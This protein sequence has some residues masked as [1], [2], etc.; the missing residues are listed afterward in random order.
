[1]PSSSRMRALSSCC[2]LVVL[3]ILLLV[4]HAPLFLNDGVVMDDWLVLKLRPDYPIDL[5]FLVHGAGHPIFFGYYRLI[6]Q[7]RRQNNHE[8]TVQFGNLVL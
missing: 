7:V 4:A 1:M 3:S 6:N 2:A 5:S 8:L